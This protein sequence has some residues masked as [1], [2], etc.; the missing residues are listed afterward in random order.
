M[1]QNLS[2]S[3]LTS[4]YKNGSL[5][6]LDYIQH[7]LKLIEKHNATK[8]NAIAQYM[9]KE[10]I[11]QK[12]KE[13][14][15]RYKQNKPLSNLDGITFTIKDTNGTKCELLNCYEA[16]MVLFSDTNYRKQDAINPMLAPVNRIERAM[17]HY[18]ALFNFTNQPAISVNCGYYTLEDGVVP[19]GM[20]IVSNVNQD[21]VVL[22]VA[23]AVEKQ[24][25]FIS[26]K[27]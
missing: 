4:L 5:T 16:S 21:N 19:I 10:Y 22:R 13:S 17:N 9:P 12:A 27:L 7:Q 6:P 24:C 25:K 2:I 8:I 23:Y 18:T 15:Q 26:A 11:L 14:T 3:K 1:S 20:Q